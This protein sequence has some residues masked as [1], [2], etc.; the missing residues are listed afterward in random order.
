MGSRRRRC[1]GCWTCWSGDDSDS[2]GRSGL[3]GG[4]PDWHA[5]RHEQPGALNS[6]DA[7]RDPHAGD[8]CV[9]RGARG[10]LIK[11]IWHDGIGMSLYAKLVEYGRFLWWRS[12]PPSWP[13]YSTGSTGGISPAMLGCS[14]PTPLADTLRRGPQAGSAPGGGLLDPCSPAFFAMFREPNPEPGD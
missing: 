5:S 4:W 6:G 8:L 9:F 10:D 11:I 2:L 12:R 13:T 3:A 1:D 7:G 14:R